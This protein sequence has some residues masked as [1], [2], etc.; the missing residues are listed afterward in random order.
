M[1]KLLLVAALASSPLAFGSA[2]PNQK[3]LDQ[4]KSAEN[5]D[6]EYIAQKQYGI[7]SNNFRDLYR[8]CLTST[9]S[10]A[11]NIRNT[12]LL[13]GIYRKMLPALLERI[14]SSMAA[15][16]EQIQ[17]TKKTNALLAQLIALQTP[18][19]TSQVASF[20]PAASQ[21]MPAP[22]IADATKK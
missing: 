7:F 18:Q 15:Q 20:A 11:A 3:T 10:Q 19:T 21:S 8:D 6:W 14:D 12:S 1:K 22:T 17:E 5:T 9:K 13:E 2:Q 16:Q 4:K